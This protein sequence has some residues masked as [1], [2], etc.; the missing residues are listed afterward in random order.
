MSRFLPE[1]RNGMITSNGRRGRTPQSSCHQQFTYGR[2]PALST[3]PGRGISAHEGSL[4]LA[5]ALDRGRDLHRLAVFRNGAA[6]D[7]DAGGTQLLDDA[8]VRQDA[9]GGLAI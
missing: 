7:V 3:R 5:P 2:V 1:T 6:R 9:V 8:V 4:L